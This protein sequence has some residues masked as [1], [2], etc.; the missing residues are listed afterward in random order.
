MQRETKQ[1]WLDLCPEAVVVED[2]GRFLELTREIV[3][4]R[5]EKQRRLSSK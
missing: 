4:I 5:T 2:P 3:Q 1:R